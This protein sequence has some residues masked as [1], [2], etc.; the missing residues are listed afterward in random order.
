[1]TGYKNLQATQIEKIRC[2]I[3][4]YD[5]DNEGS[6]V[7][8]VHGK[9]NGLDISG[10]VTIDSDGD[11]MESVECFD[12]DGVHNCERAAY[13]FCETHGLS[14]STQGLLIADFRTIA[15]NHKEYS[16]EFYSGGEWFADVCDVELDLTSYKSG[17][18][19]TTRD[20]EKAISE[21]L[22]SFVNEGE[23]G[24]NGA[25]VDAAWRL[26]DQFGDEYE[27]HDITVMIEPNHNSLIR[28]AAVE[29]FGQYSVA[30]KVCGFDEDDHEWIS[31]V[32]V[33][34]GIEENP[35]VFATGGTSM[36]F[37]S[38]CKNCKLRR[39]EHRH[40]SQRNPG[41]HDSVRYFFDDEIEDDDDFL[42]EDN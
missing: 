25:A 41:E 22:K 32:D 35:G 30:D 18:V 26:V 8:A 2:E 11:S 12:I 17:G 7:V 15:E 37:Y 4:S 23:W 3:V 19:C 13:D 10:L 29:H 5:F 24:D 31:T 34:G 14:D 38:H 28:D 20:C 1:M 40:G 33:D 27:H 42:G 16:I 21:A 9:V 39:E 6:Y 36:T